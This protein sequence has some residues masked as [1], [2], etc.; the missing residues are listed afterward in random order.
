MFGRIIDNNLFTP[1]LQESKL[2]ALVLN[3]NLPTQTHKLL[4]KGAQQ[5]QLLSEVSL[6]LGLN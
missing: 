5:Q 4:Q 2:I 6:H 1:S 3:Y